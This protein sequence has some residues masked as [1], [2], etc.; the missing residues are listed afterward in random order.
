MADKTELA[1]KAAKIVDDA[2][3][4]DPDAVA[5]FEEIR[6]HAAT[7]G[8]PAVRETFTILMERGFP[9]GLER[10]E[11]MQKLSALFPITEIGSIEVGFFDKARGQPDKA[12][13]VLQRCPRGHDLDAQLNK[14]RDRFDPDHAKSM[15]PSVQKQLSMLVF[16]GRDVY[17]RTIEQAPDF[18]AQLCRV[19]G[20]SADLLAALQV[21]KENTTLFLDPEWPE[22]VGIFVHLESELLDASVAR[23]ERP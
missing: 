23:A 15:W 11:M 5:G 6:K 22:R 8:F 18:V 7:I 10:T 13:L 16:I 19:C 12:H 9:P 1:R 14:L 17:R 4:R 20:L 3:R 2:R 21:D